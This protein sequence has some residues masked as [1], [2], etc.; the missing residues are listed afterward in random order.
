[1]KVLVRFKVLAIVIAVATG[2]FASENTLL[3]WQVGAA[4][5]GNV[6]HSFVEL[7]NNGE[8]SVNLNG[9]S[10]QYAEGTRE[11][12]AA[13]RP[14]LA[15]QDGEWGK[16]DLSGTILPKHS[17]LILGKKGTGANPAL[18]IADN[19]GDI[20]DGNFEVSNRSFKV[21][22]L[23]NTAALTVQNPFDI[24]GADTKAIGY[25]DMVG[26]MNT[27][28]E[29]K[30][31]GYESNP[32]T[33]LNK[34][35]GQRRKTLTD[36]DDN[37]YDFERAVYAG[38]N[39]DDVEFRR[40]KNHTHGEW[41]P[42]KSV[43]PPSILP[44]EGFG[45]PVIRIDTE[46]SVPILNKEDWVNMTFVLT[47]TDNPENNIT[48]IGLPQY[49]RIRGRGN[50]TWGWPKKP[51]R[52]RFRENISFFGLPARENWI[53]LAEYRDPTFLI[54]P[55][56]LELGRN[57]FDYQPFTCSYH[58]VHVYLNGKYDG[59]YIL[60]EHRQAD[61]LGVGAP[62]RV[63]IDPTNGWFVELGNYDEA[64]KFRTKNYNLPIMISAPDFGANSA[65]PKYDFVKNDWN[66][67]CDSLASA[68]FPENG[69]GD[70]IDINTFIDFS[71]IQEI[72]H[73]PEFSI[74]ASVFS[75]KDI[76]GKISMGPL[77]DFDATFG[78]ATKP[79]QNV[80]F[81]D[82]SFI[83]DRDPVSGS[84][85]WKASIYHNRH[86]FFQRF[87]DDPIFLAKYKE[88]WN[89]KYDKLVEVKY[90]IEELGEKVRVSVMEDHKR[91]ILGDTPIDKGA[92]HSAIYDIDHARQVELMT[93][94]WERRI[95]W[96]NT[97]L[98]KVE[99]LPEN[100][101]FAEQT[102]GY[103]QEVSPQKFTLVSYGDMENL[104]ATI[105]K[106]NLSD[107][108]ISAQLNK[109]PTENGGYLATISVKPKSTLVLATTYTDTLILS[110]T[111][112]NKPFEIKVPLNFVVKAPV[113]IRD[114]KTADKN[115]YIKLDSNVVSQ[116]AKIKIIT[117]KDAANINLVI[118][119]NSGNV[120]FEKADRNGAQITWNLTNK[121]GR[122]VANGSYLIIAEA[123]STNGAKIYRYQKKIGVKR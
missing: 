71:M 104:S 91:W 39:L 122:N 73:A 63:K 90:F 66:K 36:T 97:E 33:D 52:I 41:N 84:L 59:V 81:N 2:V 18:L 94:W 78:L 47:D 110:G 100:K 56:A 107:F 108:E 119:D 5:D 101:T 114:E 6:S 87:F 64:P 89:E 44:I 1:M 95:Q 24:D 58:H 85:S 80:L 8:Q 98:N 72:V 7:Y 16:I 53:L 42:V 67:L 65:D 4:T 9:Y 115:Y 46:N 83:W 37:A 102:F 20:N 14:N 48:R 68:N 70:L 34:Q 74:L 28:G 88:R 96:L 30:I 79:E 26:A 123:R 19:Y 86:S 55:T 32:I 118:Y 109:T 45:L 61:P 76:N 10:L 51:Y 38:A 13:N 113:S 49:D 111:N 21:V 11:T 82:T 27:V 29:D 69:Y 23:S 106:S 40:P 75:Y 17:F 50:S 35:T 62:G 77:W 22:L 99:V 43:L 112:Q 57:V 12:N 93:G 105:K 120:I 15:T 92:I 31:N 3:I 25:V 116:S 54:T 121:A 60:T 117:P 103:T